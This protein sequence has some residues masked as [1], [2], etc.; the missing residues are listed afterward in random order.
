MELQDDH[1]WNLAQRFTDEE[2]IRTFAL[3]GLKLQEYEIKSALI[4]NEPNVHLAAHGL[5]QKWLNR[6]ECRAKAYQSLHNFLK[7]NEFALFATDLERWVRGTPAV[8]HEGITPKSTQADLIRFF[9]TCK[10]ISFL[11]NRR[12]R[13]DWP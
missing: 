5:L 10:I 9:C 3:R 8:E 11:A 1:V 7:E 2:Q 13:F 4:Q 12:N 6:Q